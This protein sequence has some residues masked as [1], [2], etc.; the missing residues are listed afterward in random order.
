MV[1]CTSNL[2]S[3]QRQLTVAL[4]QLRRSESPMRGALIVKA[5][6]VWL[7]FRDAECAPKADGYLGN[8][9]NSSSI[10]ACTAAMNY[11]RAAELRREFRN[12]L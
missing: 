2:A 1:T 11:S 4:S 7:A 8:T 12:D 5:H 10:I 9:M 3:S 6:K